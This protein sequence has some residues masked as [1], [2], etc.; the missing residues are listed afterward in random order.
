MCALK[1]ILLGR[2]GLDVLAMCVNIKQLFI[3]KLEKIKGLLLFTDFYHQGLVCGCLCWVLCL[4]QFS[5]VTDC[6]LL[7]F[8][9]INQ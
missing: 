4:I 9:D 8:L 7:I 2:K 6:F 1:S 3:Q 5:K